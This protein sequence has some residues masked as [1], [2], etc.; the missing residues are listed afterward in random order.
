M[1]MKT[2]GA[3]TAIAL[4]LTTGAVTAGNALTS[5]ETGYT[6]SK[7]RVASRRGRSYIIASSYEGTVMGVDYSGSVLWQNKLSGYFNHDVWCEDITGD[8]SDEILAANADGAVYC[9]DSRGRLLWSF[10]P[11]HAPM[12]AVCVV[13]KD[14][15]P[16]VVCGGYDLSFYYVDVRGKLVKAIHSSTYSREKPWGPPWKLHQLPNDH[17]HIANFIRKVPKSD[18]SDILVVNGLLA[19][20]QRIG[21]FYLFEPL[22]DL[23]YEWYNPPRE[24]VDQRIGSFRV[25]DPDGDGVY[26][27]IAG[28]SKEYQRARMYRYV[29]ENGLFEVFRLSEFKNQ[30]SSGYRCA[31]PEVIRDGEDYKYLTIYGNHIVLIPSDLDPEEAEV[32]GTK[33]AFNDM[34]R[35][36]TNGRIILASA[37]SGGSCVHVIDVSNP[38]WKRAYS[39]LVPPGNIQTILAESAKL[40]EQLREFIPPQ[41]QNKSQTV[42]LMSEIVTEST[43]ELHDELVANFDNPVF[44]RMAKVD[45]QERSWREERGPD[46]KFLFTNEVYRNKRDGRMNYTLTPDQVVETIVGQSEDVP[47]VCYWGG[48]GNDPFMFAPDTTRRVLDSLHARGKSTIMVYPEMG[49]TTGNFQ[50]VLD[51][52]FYPI[53]SHA[54]Q[55]SAK[56]YIRSKGDCWQ[57]IAYL[58][59]YKRILSGEFADVF[60]PAL[61]ETGSKFP[62]LSVA[63]RMGMWCSGAADSWGSRA[64]RDNTSYNGL[65]K[66]CHQRI[67]SHFLRNMIYNISC[68]AQ[69]IM[70]HAVV[71]QDYMS[72][73]WELVA[74]GVLYVPKHSEVVSINPVHLGMREPDPDYLDEGSNVKW[75]SFYDEKGV[76]ND[77]MVF[78]RMNG[79]WPAAAVTEW[80]FS[81]YAAGVK[82]RRLD[83]LPPYPHGIVLIT[84]PQNGMFAEDAPRGKL[85]DHLHPI[86]RE[87][88][89]EQITDGKYYYSSDGVR[90]YAASQHYKTVKAEIERMSRKLPLTVSGDVAWVAAQTAP[91]HLRLT[92]IDSGYINPKPRMAQVQFHT[93]K[94][95][96]M[97]DL[98]N[99][100]EF[101]ADRGGRAEIPVPC[102][103]FRFIDIELDEAL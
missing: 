95:V 14:G 25:C 79:T 19:L 15:V 58:P 34:W 90:T 39:E 59:M 53:A 88:M 21:H 96:T 77:Q 7:V 52:L 99:G 60:V 103:M 80:D 20:N 44:L 12:N 100:D 17:R 5:I 84:P 36:T 49:D 3:I 23:P 4:G 63:G 40:R 54:R 8:G 72:L 32:I 94:P 1:T 48:H 73:L 46:G 87:I 66:H 10:K 45:K 33:C 61:E 82:E 78:S 35:D 65:R 41:G 27:V 64:V 68:G 2:V 55:R 75:L 83:F 50:Y 31:Q 18:G 24:K 42:Y 74:R 29:P 28:S 97:T 71:D 89:K 98:L 67:P 51:N 93:V 70:N 102:G 47:G 76:K 37:Q 9:L 101:R 92:V 62:D 6:I 38:D 43:R 56:F 26:E 57:S 69:Y 91:K 16:Y 11:T 22:A 86:Y 13:R 30:F 81:R 85:V